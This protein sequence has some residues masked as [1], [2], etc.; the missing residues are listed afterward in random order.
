MGKKV[1]TSSVL[2]KSTR[3]SPKDRRVIMPLNKQNQISVIDTEYDFEQLK[4]KGM[5]PKHPEIYPAVVIILQVPI[6]LMQWDKRKI[7]FT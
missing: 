2:N 1:W 6:N 4:K 7:V 5:N 3:L